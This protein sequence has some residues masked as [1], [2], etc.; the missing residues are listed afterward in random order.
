MATFSYTLTALGAN[1]SAGVLE[2]QKDLLLGKDILFDGDLRL[3]SAGDYVLLSGLEA[4]RQS[5][6]RRLLTRPGE[7]RVRPEYGVGVMEFVKKRRTRST[8]DVLRQRVVDQLSFDTRIDEV[9][10][11]VIDN[12]E[13]GIKIGIVIRVNGEALKFEPF[14]FKAGTTIGTLQNAQGA[15]RIG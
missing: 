14:E 2:G 10:D 15:L 3:N 5:I 12:I 11:V 9:V 8:F 13:D 7:Y 6:Y 1:Q 4:V